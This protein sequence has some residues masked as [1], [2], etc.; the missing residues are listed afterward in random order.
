MSLIICADEL[1]FADIGHR[2]RFLG[3]IEAIYGESPEQIHY[4]RC[5]SR[6]WNRSPAVCEVLH[7]DGRGAGTGGDRHPAN[8]G[9]AGN[10]AAPARALAAWPGVHLLQRVVHP[11]IA[12]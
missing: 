7:H 10:Q 11:L 5:S 2:R 9:G 6:T 12:P 3:P 1:T 4:L 8:C